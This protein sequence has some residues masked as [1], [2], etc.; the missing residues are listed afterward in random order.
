[1]AMND[2][3]LEDLIRSR[4]RARAPH[5]V[6]ETLFLRAA[7][8]PRQAREGRRRWPAVDT[9]VRDRRLVFMTLVVAVAVLGS[10]LL[11]ARLGNPNGVASPA[12]PTLPP[13]TQPSLPPR[14][15]NPTRIVAGAWVS[16]T[17][18]WLVDD[19][20]GLRMTTDGGQSW[21]NPR[22]LPRPQDELRGGPTFMDD[23]T[24][25]AVW[26]PQ[27]GNPVAVWVYLTHDGGRTWSS[28]HVGTLASQAGDSNSLTAHFSDPEHG[29]VLAGDYRAGPVPSGHAG[30]GLQAA[31]CAGWSTSDGGATW[32]AIPGAPCSDHDDWASPLVGIL[33]PVS[34][35]GPTVSLTLDGGLTW[36]SGTL[37]GVGVDDAPIYVVFTIAPDGSPRLAYWVDRRNGE[38]ATHGAVTVVE[39][40]DGGTS[41]EEAYEF[42]PPSA[43]SLDTV[44]ALGSDHWVATGAASQST[45]APPVPILETADGGRTWVRVGTLGSIDGQSLG[46]YDRLHGTASGQDNSG[47][48]LPS[49]TPCHASGFFLTNDGGQTWHGVPF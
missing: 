4:L 29:V 47:C 2:E 27:G 10:L 43:L 26:A 34:D 32:I 7:G 3:P 48:S 33:M 49:G 19:Q 42:E 40:H 21:S 14:A 28:T 22:P 31:A 6:P 5:D 25:F 39:S 36:R 44:T 15:A 46:W 18:A 12:I 45:A 16:P 38:P 13:V 17:V 41:W 37:P 24:G 1:M 8:I 35:G 23:S 9:G 11:I 30:A 20:N